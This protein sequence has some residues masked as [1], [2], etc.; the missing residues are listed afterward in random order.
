MDD[1]ARPAGG[2]ADGPGEFEDFFRN[3][4]ASAARA[5]GLVV[6]DPELGQDIAQEA[7]AR[8]FGRWGRMESEEHARNF[9]LRVGLNLARSH[10]RR[11][12][13]FR[14]LIGTGRLEPRTSA[15]PT[16][17]R[18]EVFEALGRLSGRQRA[19]LVLV[20]YLDLGDAEAGRILGLAPSTI[21]VHLAR[22]RAAMRALLGDRQPEGNRP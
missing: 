1:E 7:F 13:R 6:R 17:R 21:R 15:A 8:V 9:V 19:C 22:G 5:L 20:D 12:R 16:D 11:E 18:V 14:R 3:R 4:F 2:S 10:Q